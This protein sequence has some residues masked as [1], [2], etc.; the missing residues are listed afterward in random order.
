MG[1]ATAP[2][3]PEPGRPYGP[4]MTTAASPETLLAL[5]FA[6]TAARALH[7]VAELGVAD[8]LD[9]QPRDAPA[10]AGDLGADPDALHRL[11]RL[12][13]MHGVFA[14]DAAG[15]WAHTATSRVLRTDHPMSVRAFARMAG[16]A[17][18]WDSFTGLEHSARTGEPGICLLEPQGWTAYL[19]AHQD[20]AIIFQQAMTAKG[21]EDIQAA[22]AAYDFSRH[23][24]LVDVAGG[25]GHLVRAVLAAHDGV[26]GVLFDLPEVA[27][28]VLPQE[29]L[30]VASGDFFTDALPAGDAY[31]LMNVVHDWDDA[32]SVRIL[33][34]VAAAGRP[35]AATVLLLEVLMPEGP[36]PDWA[37][38]LDIVMLAITG[39]RERSLPEYDALL[40]AAGLELVGVTPTATPFFILEARV[41]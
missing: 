22:L 27:Q 35:A 41:R 8:H 20:E 21:H 25:H 14:C 24:R 11:L 36:A 39:G 4:A 2:M 40:T 28:Q 12:L 33:Q 34:A 32:A 30:E 7:V 3:P 18:G 5:A 13:E 37:K 16:S 31:V 19:Q 26:E 15:S 9:D 6:H 10:L 23:R 29:R 17:F 1:C 38:A